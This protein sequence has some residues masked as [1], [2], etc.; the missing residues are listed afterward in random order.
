MR[1]QPKLIV[2]SNIEFGIV[3][4]LSDSEIIN[5][6]GTAVLQ[7]KALLGGHENMLDLAQSS[8]SNRPMI[9]I[10]G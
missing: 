4:G 7:K 3:A 10:G 9:L 8:N 1:F 5:Q 2:L 6:I